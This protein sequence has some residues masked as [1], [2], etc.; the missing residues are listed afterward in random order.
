MDG[1]C[2]KCGFIKS[3]CE[4]DLYKDSYI[5]IKPRARKVKILEKFADHTRDSLLLLER[6]INDFIKDVQVVDIQY[7]AYTVGHCF[8]RS[9]M[10]VYEEV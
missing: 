4:C 3:Q 10:I 5:D 7:S 2:D 9:A 1:Y 6:D 8:Y